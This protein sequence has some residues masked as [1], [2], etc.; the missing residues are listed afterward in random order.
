MKINKMRVKIAR[1]FERLYNIPY[2]ANKK[3]RF[4]VRAIVGLR[5]IDRAIANPL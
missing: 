3:Y 1:Q 2:Y 5:G 4:E